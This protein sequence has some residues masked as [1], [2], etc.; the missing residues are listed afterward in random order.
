MLEKMNTI[1]LFRTTRDVIKADRLGNDCGLHPM[2]RPVPVRIA[3][4]CG[5]CIEVSGHET[6]PFIELMNR[7]AI[8]MKIYEE[9]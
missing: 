2:V 5:M 6:T 7:N 9:F 8:E 1:I 3:A 4:Q